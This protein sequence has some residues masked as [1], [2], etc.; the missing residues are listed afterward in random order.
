MAV[1]SDKVHLLGGLGIKVR[2]VSAAADDIELDDVAI[3]CDTSSNNVALTLPSAAE[4]YEALTASEG[5]GG[6]VY[7]V[8]HTTTGN[9][10][11]VARAGSD[12]INGTTSVTVTNDVII[13]PVSASAWR[14]LAL[15][16][17]L[18]SESLDGTELADDSIDSRHYVAASIDNEHLADDAVNS[19]EL[20][21]G[22]VDPVHLATTDYRS[23]ADDGA[24][25][26]GATDKVVNLLSSTTGTKAATMTAT[27]QGHLVYV[28]LVARAGGEYTLACKRD[29][30]SV[31]VTL[32]AATEG[33]IICYDGSEWQLLALLG[34]ATAA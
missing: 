9:T 7:I 34:G 6:G 33:C 4:A 15:N 26:L 17:A 24:L 16:A 13:Y 27:H 21:D 3:S 10:C 22:A 8:S 18:S 5:K 19:G 2:A 1:H 20:A 11:S 29:A 14:A 25:T 28:H 31:T 30:A 23:V 12:T 32:D